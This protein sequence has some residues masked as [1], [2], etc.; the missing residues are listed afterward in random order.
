MA[1]HT[2]RAMVCGRGH[3]PL[4]MLRYESCCPDSETDS[5]LIESTFQRY[6]EWKIMVR[7]LVD[8][9]KKN[10]RD[11]WFSGR[12]S[13]FSCYLEHGDA[14]FPSSQHGFKSLAEIRAERGNAEADRVQKSCEGVQ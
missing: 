6:G 2:V 10:W 5:Y 11:Y 14:T 8:G 13:S 4:D 1:Y 9:K 3:F 7:K 12:W